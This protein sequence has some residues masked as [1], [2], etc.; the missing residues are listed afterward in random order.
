MP[1]SSLPESVIQNSQN[2]T[3]PQQAAL[4]FPP[5]SLQ[6]GTTFQFVQYSYDNQKTNAQF[7]TTT[8]GAHIFLPLPTQLQQALSLS[9]EG[10]DMGGLG[11][12]FKAGVAAA[13]W[14]T[15]QLGGG[16][17]S[18]NTSD[19]INQVAKATGAGVE[20]ILR[21]YAGDLTPGLESAIDQYTGTVVNP[22][23][24]ATFKHTDSRQFSLNFMLIPRTSD[25][26]KQIKHICDTFQYHSLPYKDT[27]AVQGTSIGGQSLFLDMPDEVNVEFY[28]STFLYK[29]ARCVITNVS[30]D[31]AP[32]GTPSFFP[33]GAPTAVS[34]T[35]GLQE[36][37][38]LDRS[39]FDS[40]GEDFS[41]T[42]VDTNQKQN[43]IDPNN[44]P[45]SI[46][47]ATT[48]LG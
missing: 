47:D 41:D 37:Q 38:Q 4:S 14:L 15:S 12:S 11:M 21:K 16:G 9:Y 24:V 42:G 30:I 10:V 40:S 23:N 29:F 26:S 13:D 33:D 46:K 36:I 45:G 27:G 20:Y 44:I 18:A 1:V 5:E 22:Y 19:T 32:F 2:N 34:L 7:Q 31:Y 8:A 48:I 28:G 3:S 25:E 39:A 43:T 35:I 17:G 6:Y